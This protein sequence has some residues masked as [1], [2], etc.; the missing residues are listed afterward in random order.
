MPALK[1]KAEGKASKYQTDREEEVGRDGDQDHWPM[2]Q[3]QLW[4]TISN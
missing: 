4:L 3:P 1:A 2:L